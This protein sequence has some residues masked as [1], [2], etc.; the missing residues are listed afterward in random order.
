M[1]FNANVLPFIQSKEAETVVSSSARLLAIYSGVRE[2][3]LRARARA[4]EMYASF[5]KLPFQVS[6]LRIT[7]D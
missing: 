1:K 3:I 7:L 4:T 5:T 6:G 2:K